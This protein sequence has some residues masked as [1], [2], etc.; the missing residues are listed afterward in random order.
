MA[1]FS[2][3]INTNKVANNLLDK[4][5]DSSLTVSEKAEGVI[6]MMER[7]GITPSSQTRRIVTWFLLSYIMVFSFLVS[8]AY[9]VEKTIMVA[10]EQVLMGDKL[11]DIFK[12][13]TSNSITISIV[14]FFYGGYYISKNVSPRLKERIEKR[15]Q[16]RELDKREEELKL[17]KK[18]NRQKRRNIKY[19]E[20]NKI[21]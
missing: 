8:I 18:E 3:F 1:I 7:L 16:N 2:G 21:D 15:K 9:W 11:L 12:E 19:E 17:S 5:D 4:F 6:A 14:G 10:G 13:V 20:R